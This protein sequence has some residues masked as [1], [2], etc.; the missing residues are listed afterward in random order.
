[1][2]RG[3]PS[4]AAALLLRAIRTALLVGDDDPLAARPRLRC[5]LRQ[6]ARCAG[7]GGA[8]ARAQEET[9]CS[10]HRHHTARTPSSPVRGRG[11]G[12]HAPIATKS[13]LTFTAVFALVSIKKMPLSLAYDSASCVSRR[14]AASELRPARARARLEAAHLRL[15]LALGAQ[16]G[17]V[18]RQRDHN[19]GVPLPLQLLHPLLRALE[20]ILRRARGVSTARQPAAELGLSCARAPGS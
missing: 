5:V 1:M 15:D 16:V 11:P 14:A 13:S 17:L 10:T 2:E 7:S 19:V 6:L 20:R 8:S 18:A 3:C 4:A 12:G 9:P